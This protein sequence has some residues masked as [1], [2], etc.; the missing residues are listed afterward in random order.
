MLGATRLLAIVFV[1]R[2][3]DQFF[4]LPGVFLVDSKEIYKMVVLFVNEAGV[5]ERSRRIA[6]G[7]GT[8]YNFRRQDC[9]SDCFSRRPFE[10]H[11]H[12]V[13]A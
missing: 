2:H 9:S 11:S 10:V 4:G 1:M 5:F 12:P 13:K 7:R 8:L 6:M 3:F